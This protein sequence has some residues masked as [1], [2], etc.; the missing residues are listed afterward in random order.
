MIKSIGQ[1]ARK[2]I[3]EAASRSAPLPVREGALQLGRRPERY[4]EMG[5]EFPRGG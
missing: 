3:A 5:L 2:D 1:A 4:R